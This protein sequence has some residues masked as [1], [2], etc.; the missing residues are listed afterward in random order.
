MFEFLSVLSFIFATI[1]TLLILFCVPTIIL[2]F[3]VLMKF[4]K[5]L[6]QKDHD[7]NK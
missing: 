3:K 4:N 6:N 5:Y 1:Q 2:L 7:E